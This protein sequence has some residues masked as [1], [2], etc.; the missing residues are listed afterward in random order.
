MAV[1]LGIDLGTQSLKA[2]LLDTA[3]GVLNVQSE[4]Y[5]ICIPRAGWAEETPETW[6]AALKCVLSKMRLAKP[7]AFDAIKSIGFSGQMHGLVPVDREN[8]PVCPAIIWV[9]QR[10]KRQ[11]AEIESAYAHQELAELM[12]NHVFTGFGF[13]SL[14]WLK[15]ERPDL[16]EKVYKICAPKDYL[17]LKLV[18]GDIETDVSD[19]SSMTGF[20]FTKRTWSSQVLEKF[21]LPSKLFPVCHE[22][23][24][25][26]GAISPAA[27]RETGLP[28]G[29]QVVCGSGDI[30]AL[31]LGCGMYREGVGIINIGTGATYS[32]YSQ[33]DVYDSKLRLQEFCN[34]I[35]KSYILCGATLSGGL[36]LSW[37]KD[38]VL[39]IES[40][41]EIN[42][43]AAAVPAGN[44]GLIFLPYLGGERA[45]HM[46]YNA[47]GV[48]F[49]MQHVHGKK[50]FCRAVMEGVVYAMK[51]CDVLMADNGIYCDT[52]I[53]SGGGAKS[54]LWLQIQADVLEKEILV[55]AVNEEACLGACLIAG[56]GSGI[57][58]SPEDACAAN[59]VRFQDRRYEPNVHNSEIYRQRY[60]IY[61]SLYPLLKD[62]MKNNI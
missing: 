52:I 15:E 33:T 44:E 48:F 31:S 57:F 26:V 28:V 12:H 39:G 17:R 36:S 37:L 30:A 40:Y 38:K 41:D 47:T 46:D 5:E 13:P 16:Y 45:P 62:Q 4:A 20:D 22:A 50:H 29:A 9:D 53:A 19:A 23:T 42:R 34:A 49:G 11:V 59:L 32:C 2:M 55:T 61:R 25:L 14:L 10:A 56:I 54:S 3:S 18:G 35:N 51:D 43:L 7:V 27:A 1:I 6:W 60:E 24:D 8:R 21:D 58:R